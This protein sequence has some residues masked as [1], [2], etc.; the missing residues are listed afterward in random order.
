V[1]ALKMHANQMEHM[2]KSINSYLTYIPRLDI[3]DVGSYDVNG[4]YRP[5]FNKP[6]WNYI[7]VD[8]VAGSNVDIV[9]EDPYKFPFP[10][11]HFDLVISGSAFEHIDFFWL[12]FQEMTRV[13][14]PPG[15]IF[16]CA[17]SQWPEHRYPVDCWRFLPDGFRALAKYCSLEVL[18]TYTD[19][20]IP[21]HGDTIGVFLKVK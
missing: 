8:V 19:N 15:Y 9:L 10:D 13:L 14:K 7:G 17:P 2:S 6:G 5:L 16:L 20:F 18:E 3:L 1:E 12:I 11:N 4:S 21:D